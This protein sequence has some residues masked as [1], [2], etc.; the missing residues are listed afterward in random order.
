MYE[1]FIKGG[2]LMWPI[3]LCSIAT[4]AIIIER[5][6]RY[7]KIRKDFSDIVPSLKKILNRENAAEAIKFCEG[8]S[9]LLAHVLGKAITLR[10]AGPNDREIIIANAGSRLVR[11]L[12]QYLRALAII[13]NI[14]PLLGLLGTVVGMIKAFIKIQTLGGRVDASVL[15]GGIWEALITTAAGLSVAIPALIAYY[16]FEGTAHDIAMETKDT[17]IDIL[18]NAKSPS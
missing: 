16:Y 10:N 2:L 3:L 12:E 7:Y 8:K 9:G 14:A 17:T 5:T 15:A 1:M 4:M 6:Y 13:G 18:G 11:N